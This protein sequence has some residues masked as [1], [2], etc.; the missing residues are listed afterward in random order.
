M[1]AR[2]LAAILG[3]LGVALGAFGAH[4]LK[5][6][7]ANGDPDFAVR[8]LEW[9]RTATIYHLAHALAILATTG[10]DADRAP[11]ASDWSFTAGIAIFCG[12]LYAMSLGAPTWFGAVTPFGGLALLAGWAL[13]LR[14][15]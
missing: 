14:R 10:S 12:S 7:L 13:L 9:W 4:G 15:G 6:H 2:R 1:T 11:S 3:F 5:S 8:A